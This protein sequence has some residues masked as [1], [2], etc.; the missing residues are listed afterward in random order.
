M[1]EKL[2][3]D[4]EE[5]VVA[6]KQHRKQQPSKG[7]NEE[8]SEEHTSELQSP[9][10]IVCRLLLEKKKSR[11]TKHGENSWFEGGHWFW[12]DRR[13]RVTGPPPRIPRDCTAPARFPGAEVPLIADFVKPSSCS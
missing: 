4:Q 2:R 12:L 9:D 6:R 13:G 10:H 11:L 1:G 8:R 3:V 7:Q 5:A